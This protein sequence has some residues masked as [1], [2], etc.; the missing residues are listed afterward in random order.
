LQPQPQPPPQPAVVE[1]VATVS[2]ATAIHHSAAVPAALSSIAAS[3]QPQPPQ[4]QPPDPAVVE[5]VPTVILAT[6]F[7]QSAAV[8]ASHSTTAASLQPQPQSQLAVVEAMH[9]TETN[10]QKF[11]K[12]YVITATPNVLKTNLCLQ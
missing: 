11:L 12:V 1:F 10:M 2:S 4:L 7:H 3:L 6:A 5:V 8:P 9:F